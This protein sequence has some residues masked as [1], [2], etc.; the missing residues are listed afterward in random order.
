LPAESARHEQDD[1]DGTKDLRQV[2]IDNKR[3]R[4][5]EL[6]QSKGR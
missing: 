4:A 2:K 6:C 1:E 5:L 3:N